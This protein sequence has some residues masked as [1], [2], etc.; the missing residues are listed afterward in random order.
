MNATSFFAPSPKIMH[1][2]NFDFLRLLFAVLVI[3]SHSY[4]LSGDWSGGDILYRNTGEH[5][6]FSYLGVS[7]F[8]ILS[9]YLIFQSLLRSRNLIEY[10]WKR[11]LRLYPALFVV[12]VL[13]VILSPFVYEGSLQNY[14][15]EKTAWT[16]IPRNLALLQP[17]FHINGV[18][19]SGAINGSLW[20]IG[21]EFLFYVGLSS[22]FFFKNRPVVL[23]TLL[24]VGFITLFL[25]KIFL[26]KTIGFAALSEKPYVNLAIYFV[27][28]SL[29]AAF[30]IEDFKNRK[31]LFA[32]GITGIT[33]A[34]FF[35]FFNTAEFL[36]L[37]L[38]VLPFGI[39]STRFINE[40]GRV[41]GDL[42]Y[43]MYIYA[44]PVAQ[45]LAHYFSLSAGEMM[46]FSLLITSICAYFSWHFIEKKALKLKKL[47]PLALFKKREVE[48]AIAE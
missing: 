9:G 26:F 17:Q 19:K 3:V 6:A 7:G 15:T 42:S 35:N 14:L 2:N 39:A 5:V 47:Q 33:A 20:T 10:F 38:I 31:E 41:I 12:L 45:A 40:T 44:F 37:P 27:S 25:G 36:F 29:L 24:A 22:L 28:G 32:V 21:F 46:V 43:G 8:F 13:T 30:K 34:L 48:V 16:Y 23:K 1:K 11:L 18:F 4:S